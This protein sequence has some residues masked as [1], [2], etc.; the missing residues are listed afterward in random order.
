MWI[1]RALE[2]VWP[3]FDTVV[4]GHTQKCI[5]YPN[6]KLLRH[7]RP[8]SMCGSHTH[9]YT[10]SCSYVAAAGWLHLLLWPQILRSTHGRDKKLFTRTGNTHETVLAFCKHITSL[11][12]NRQCILCT[13]SGPKTAINSGFKSI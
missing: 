1:P 3:Q 6:G 7:T 9:T 10:S 11:S 2:V 5:L 13:V 4:V 8:H 12:D